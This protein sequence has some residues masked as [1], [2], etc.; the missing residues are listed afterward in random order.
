[1]GVAVFRECV[2]GKGKVWVNN[3]NN[4]EE[5]GKCQEICEFNQKPEKKK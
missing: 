5:A 3:F 2:K 4:C 1:M